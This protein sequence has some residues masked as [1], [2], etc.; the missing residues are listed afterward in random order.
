MNPVG[1]DS[2]GFS[3]AL[4]YP[5]PYT[6][7][8][9]DYTP[10]VPKDLTVTVNTNDWKFNTAGKLQL[11]AGGDII[12]SAGETVLGFAASYS[13]GYT[14]LSSNPG[15]IT[16][17]GDVTETFATGQVLKFSTLVEDE[18]TAGTVAFDSGNNWTTIEL[19]EGLGGPVDGDT[20]Y[21]EKYNISEI[22]PGEGAAFTLM[23]NVLTIAALPQRLLNGSKQITLGTDG[24]TTFPV[25][26]VP[27]SS[28]G[29]VGDLAGMVA[30]DGTHIY[31]C[32]QDF[33]GDSITVYTGVNEDHFDHNA[34]YGF[35]KFLTDITGWTLTV[36]G[37]SPTGIT[38][39]NVD[40]G[41][42]GGAQ[43][44]LSFSAS[45]TY[46]STNTFTFTAPSLTNIWK[47]VAWSGDTW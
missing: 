39:T 40:Q 9:P 45:V 13:S 18:Y 3:G 27:S 29:Q 8:S 34:T 42:N 28:T 19:V 12:D 14:V 33:V 31:Y 32:T 26:A 16:V 25:A 38:V 30:F 17:S 23:N 41:F 43:T 10:A 22:Y 2:L 1:A 11:P 44:G 7:H 6:A 20:I 37:M 35:N 4:P 5:G 46:T 24:R 15:G 36:P 21:F 47:R